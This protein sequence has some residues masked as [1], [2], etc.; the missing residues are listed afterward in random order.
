MKSKLRKG[1][2]LAISV[3]LPATLVALSLAV[4]Q[5]PGFVTR[6]TTASGGGRST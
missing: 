1:L 6:L 5:E 3:A 2:L 4:A